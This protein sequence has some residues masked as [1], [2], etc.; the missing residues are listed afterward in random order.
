MEIT[1]SA[2]QPKAEQEGFSCGGLISKP[3]NP[4]PP[5]SEEYGQW[6]YG[7]RNGKQYSLLQL[8]LGCQEAKGATA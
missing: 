4:Y 8:D 2:L 7:Y 5:E 3:P 6:E 1:Y